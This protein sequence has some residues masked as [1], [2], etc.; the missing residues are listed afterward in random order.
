APAAFERPVTV[1]ARGAPERGAAYAGI[2]IDGELARQLCG[3]ARAR[4]ARETA[5]K[6]TA[7]QGLGAAG[8]VARRQGAPIAARERGVDGQ[9]AGGS[10]Q[11]VAARERQP[12][13]RAVA[14]ER[15]AG[16]A[17]RAQRLVAEL[18]GEVRK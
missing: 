12:R 14:R 18:R 7:D 9:R 13:A 16:L 5:G 2:G 4:H 15:A 17:P 11:G 10:R 8:E 6:R 1:Q 3:V